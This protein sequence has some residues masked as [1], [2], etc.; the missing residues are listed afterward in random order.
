VA[1]RE[2]IPKRRA[3]LRALRTQTYCVAVMSESKGH[4]C[5]WELRNLP[6]WCLRLCGICGV[7]SGP[8]TEGF[9]IYFCFTLSQSAQQ[10]C[11]LIFIFRTIHNK[12]TNGRRERGSCNKRRQ[13]GNRRASRMNSI[14]DW[15][16]S[17]VRASQLLW[18]TYHFPRLCAVALA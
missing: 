1:A 13:F 2:T 8:E 17:R 5:R 14:I 4:S 9:S 11:I 18:Q 7:C 3:V 16:R 10:C 12:R 6:S 15:P